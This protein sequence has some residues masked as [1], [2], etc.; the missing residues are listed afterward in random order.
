MTGQPD[1]GTVR[2]T[3]APAGHV[4]ESKAVKAYLWSFRTHGAMAEDIAATI[5]GHVFQ[6]IRPRFL[7]VV[8]VQ[9]SRGGVAI[10]ATSRLDAKGNRPSP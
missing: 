8:V 2:I 5:A 9:R 4:L 1:F 7:E 3:Y 10:E 6:A